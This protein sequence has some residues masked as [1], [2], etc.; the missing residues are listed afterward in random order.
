MMNVGDHLLRRDSETR[1][2]RPD[3]ARSP[4][5]HC[6]TT[7]RTLVRGDG[8]TVARRH[9]RP[10]NRRVSAA[11]DPPG[12]AR[13]F[14][15]GARADAG[16]SMA[17]APPTDSRATSASWTLPNAAPTSTSSTRRR[18]ACRR[19]IGRSPIRSR[20]WES[21]AAA[22][23]AAACSSSPSSPPRSRRAA[24]T[25]ATPAASWPPCTTR[26]PGDRDARLGRHP[27]A[28]QL[29]RSQGLGVD[30]SVMWGEYF[31]VEALDKLLGAP[32]IQ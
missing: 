27:Q 23:A 25:D 2:P 13:R 7:R 19:T 5:E 29:P 4:R 18:S 28:R 30:E 32:A 15:L 22:I 26:V 10:R 20:R 14:L 16:R 31:F 17:S 12:L 6:L 11:D 8:S 9:L 24:A 1:R 3:C 21:S